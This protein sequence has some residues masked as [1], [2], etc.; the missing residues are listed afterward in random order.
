[1]LLIITMLLLWLQ[2]TNIK[3]LS[4]QQSKDSKQPVAI[5]IDRHTG[6]QV[7]KPYTSLSRA[8][9]R[10]DKLDN[11]YGAYRYSVKMLPINNTN[12]ESK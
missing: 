2:L 9:A 7:G 11:A 5:V 12:E 10:V 8:R 4:M 1:M 3:V 6:L